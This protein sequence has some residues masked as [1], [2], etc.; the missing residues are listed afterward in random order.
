MNT[1]KYQSTAVVVVVGGGEVWGERTA[2][3]DGGRPTHMHQ[4]R[5]QLGAASSALGDLAVGLPGGRAWASPGTNQKHIY[6]KGG[7]GGSVRSN[8]LRGGRGGDLATH[9]RKGGEKI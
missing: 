5:P 2:D 7:G 3:G 4:G 6:R 1:R 9:A 8:Q